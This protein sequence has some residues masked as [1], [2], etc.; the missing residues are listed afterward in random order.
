MFREK[1]EE[2]DRKGYSGVMVKIQIALDCVR[3]L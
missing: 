2:M 1:R 3:M